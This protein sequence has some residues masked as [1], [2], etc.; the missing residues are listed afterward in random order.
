[1][2]KIYRAK[3]DKEKINKLIENLDY[4][5]LPPYIFKTFV[6][7][8][9]SQ[10][11]QTV[12]WT[13]N[14]KK[15]QEEFFKNKKIVEYLKSLGIIFRKGQVV[16][17]EDFKKVATDWRLEIDTTDNCWLSLTCNLSLYPLHFYKTEIVD[18]YCKEEIEKLLE[19]DIIEEIEVDGE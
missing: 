14:Y 8:Y 1:M 11:A 13:M 7:D 18:E 5:S 4:Y 2:V 3:L 15:W 9:E 17:N 6:V 19:L 12:K 10:A 16:E